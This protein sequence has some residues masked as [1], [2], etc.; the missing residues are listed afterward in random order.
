MLFVYFYVLFLV[1]YSIVSFNIFRITMISK[2][3]KYFWKIICEML[4]DKEQSKDKSSFIIVCLR[5][6]FFPHLLFLI[7]CFFVLRKKKRRH[8]TTTTKN[9]SHLKKLIQR[10]F[11]KYILKQ[12]KHLCVLP[13]QILPHKICSYY[14]NLT[15]KI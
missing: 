3:N 5:N 10:I 12:N 9:I 8:N 1:F 4:T 11:Y 14:S 13:Y 15:H 2:N 7:L 6:L